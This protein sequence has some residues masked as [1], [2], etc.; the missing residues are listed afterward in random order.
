MTEVLTIAKNLIARPSI[1]PDDQG[2]QK[3]ITEYLNNLDFI[4]EN[5]PSDQISNLWSVYNSDKS[6]PK[7]RPIIAFAGHTDVVPTGPL[8]QWD[9]PPFEPTVKNN[10]LYGRGAADMKGSIAAMLVGTKNFI[11]KTPKDKIKLSIGFIITSDEE[12]PAIHGT[13]HVVN[14]LQKRGQKIDY[15]IVGEPSS[16]L[17]LGDTAKNGRRGSMT[18]TLIIYGTQGHVAYPERANNAI[19]TSLNFLQDLATTQ[20][21]TGNN[22]F[23]PTSLQITNIHSGTG[24]TNVIPGVITLDF[25]LRY[26]SC[27]SFESISLQIENL[28]IKHNLHYKINWTHYAEPFLTHSGELT[29]TVQDAVAHVTGN[30]CTMAT[31]GGTSDGR[32][33]FPA[34]N[35]QLIELGPIN[36]SIHKINEFINIDDL[37]NLVKIYEDILTKINNTII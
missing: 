6:E 14:I 13:K 33:I 16:D 37:E 23:P 36:H 3:Y 31:T 26:A 28:L 15:C 32:F 11:T 9:S 21:D 30:H 2:C 8:D 35:C 17:K 34:F 5:L 18:A 25:N 12:G 20:W 22:Y 7:S 1:T 24:A 10:N 19:H 27:S 4:S 29:T